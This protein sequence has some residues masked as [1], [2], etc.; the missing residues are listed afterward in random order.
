MRNSIESI[1]DRNLK[2]VS[3]R[4]MNGKRCQEQKPLY[5]QEK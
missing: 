3:S 1:N 5:E 4:D 2:K